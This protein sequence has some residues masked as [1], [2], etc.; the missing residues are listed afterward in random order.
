MAEKPNFALL[1]GKKLD[2]KDKGS[3]DEPEVESELSPDETES[4]KSGET[5]SMK[6]SAVSDLFAAFAAKDVEAGK[7]ALK[8]FFDLCD[9]EPH[10]EGEH[11]NEAAE[12]LPV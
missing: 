7:A 2:A 10:E 1:I 3:K 12:E 4:S 5:E 8:D 11:T 9:S 6:S